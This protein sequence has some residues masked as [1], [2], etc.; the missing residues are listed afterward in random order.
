MRRKEN[1]KE[2][3]DAEKKGVERRKPERKEGKE[4]RI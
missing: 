2:R 1:R 4:G 3:G